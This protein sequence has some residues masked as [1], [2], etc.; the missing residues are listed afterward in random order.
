MFIG[1]VE[2]TLVLAMGI[3]NPACKLIGYQIS[4]G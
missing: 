4:S 3:E 1:E 2:K